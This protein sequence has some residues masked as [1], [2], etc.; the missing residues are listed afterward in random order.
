MTKS[1][2]LVFKWKV[3]GALYASG[4]GCLL[5]FSTLLVHFDTIILPK[6]WVYI[7][8]D[9]SLSERHWIW[10]LL[11]FWVGSVHVCT[12]TLSIGELQPNVFFTTWIAFGSMISTYEVWRE[13]AGLTGLSIPSSSNSGS[14]NGLRGGANNGTSG[15]P[16]G[17]ISDA[18]APIALQPD[19]EER[20]QQT[21]QSPVDADSSSSFRCETTHN[22]IWTA[23]FSFLFACSVADVYHNRDFLEIEIVGFGPM[24]ANPK[25]WF[26]VLSVVWTEALVCV[27]AIILNESLPTNNATGLLPCRFRSCRRTS[28]N[29][30]V[31]DQIIYRCVFGWRQIEGLVIF[32]SAALKFW[33]ILTYTGVDDVISGLSNAYFGVWG[34]FFNSVFTFG[35]WLRENKNTEYIIRESRPINITNNNNRTRGS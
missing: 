28:A 7:F 9:G 2:A 31:D 18:I 35:T 33:I 6:L 3:L 16:R 32:I 20:Q 25:D 26:I 11:F 22:W 19:D 29:N 12:S 24:R 13:S 5:S 34:S 8:R 30:D 1:G 23:F 17:S 10:F 21:Q 15:R 27:L 4:I 14:A